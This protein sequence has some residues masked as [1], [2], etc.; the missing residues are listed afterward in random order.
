MPGCISFGEGFS[1]VLKVDRDEKEHLLDQPVKR[2][3]HFCM[4]KNCKTS[5]DQNRTKGYPSSAY[6]LSYSFC[7]SVEKGQLAQK[8]SKHPI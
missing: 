5:A 8:S 2:I 6:S 3:K 7:D 4:N 1:S